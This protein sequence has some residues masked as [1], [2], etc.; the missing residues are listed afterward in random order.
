MYVYLLPLFLQPTLGYQCSHTLYPQLLYNLWDK[1]P[2]QTSLLS[3]FSHEHNSPQMPCLYSNESNTLALN[4]CTHR[5]ICA[6][7]PRYEHPT[8]CYIHHTEIIMP[9]WYEDTTPHTIN[10]DFLRES[11]IGFNCNDNF[12]SSYLFFCN[13]QD[14]LSIC[15]HMYVNTYNDDDSFYYYKKWF[16][17]LVWGSMRSNLLL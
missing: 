8:A 12:W 14:Y 1:K 6:G 15:I 16:S 13:K 7:P 17:T 10:R 9:F 5:H 4:N 11:F 2:E 3:L